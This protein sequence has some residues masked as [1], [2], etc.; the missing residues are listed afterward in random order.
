[1]NAGISRSGSPCHSATRRDSDPSSASLHAGCMHERTNLLRSI[2]LWVRS[3][4][5]VV[6][7]RRAGFVSSIPCDRPSLGSFVG[8]ADDTLTLLRHK[9][10]I[11][12]PDVPILGSFWGFRGRRSRTLGS[13]VGFWD[14]E[15]GFVRRIWDPW[16]T[17]GGFVCRVLHLV[18]AAFPEA[19]RPMPH[20]RS[21]SVSH[22]PPA[23]SPLACAPRAPNDGT[24]ILNYRNFWALRAPTS[25]KNDELIP[26][27]GTWID[28]C[29]RDGRSIGHR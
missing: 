19:Q 27:P 25:R 28:P 23:L 26:L 22:L 7:G 10:G 5:S 9:F 12:Y 3:S 14:W 13:F 1:V 15:L 16:G 17:G 24:A 21:R 29:P 6:D 20:A 11:F 8:F 2:W 18:V 4:R